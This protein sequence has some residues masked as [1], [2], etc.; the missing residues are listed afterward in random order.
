[1]CLHVRVC[2]CVCVS[3]YVWVCAHAGGGGGGGG[4]LQPLSLA[5]I[6]ES[7]ISFTEITLIFTTL[8]LK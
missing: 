7:F 6:T 3:P 2:V 4:V 1:M 5:I 8:F